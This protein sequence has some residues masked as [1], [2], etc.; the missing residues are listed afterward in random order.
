MTKVLK[1]D[2]FFYNDT[3]SINELFPHMHLSNYIATPQQNQKEK[4]SFRLTG[5]WNLIAI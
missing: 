1:Y 3:K 4:K 5:Q 2:F